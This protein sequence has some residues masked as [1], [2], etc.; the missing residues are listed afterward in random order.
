MGYGN[1]TSAPFAYGTATIQ[2]LQSQSITW[3]AAYDRTADNPSSNVE[4]QFSRNCTVLLA[5]GQLSSFL[6]L[7]V[8]L[9][10]GSATTSGILMDFSIYSVDASSVWTKRVG[11]YNVSIPATVNANNN[12]YQLRFDYS[13]VFY[14]TINPVIRAAPYL[15]TMSTASYAAFNV[16]FFTNPLLNLTAQPAVNITALMTLETNGVTPNTQ[17]RN[18]TC[19]NPVLSNITGP[20]FVNGSWTVNPYN[21]SWDYSWVAEYNRS[22]DDP[23]TA[24]LNNQFARSCTF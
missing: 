16:R 1:A 13:G 22:I 2:P 11:W 14:N 18:L 7:E 3:K 15:V 23:G 12:N 8:Q 10:S 9:A 19:P 6:S 4:N 24:N 20:P 17:S 21:K 5:P